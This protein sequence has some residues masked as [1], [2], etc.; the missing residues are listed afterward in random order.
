MVCNHDPSDGDAE[1]IV[2]DHED[3]AVGIDIAKS[4]FSGSSKETAASARFFGVLSER[5]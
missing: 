4:I 2:G 5:R 1:R 3:V